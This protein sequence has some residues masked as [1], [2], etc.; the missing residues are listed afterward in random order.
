MKTDGKN[1]VY[2]ENRTRDRSL[3]KRAPNLYPSA[4]RIFWID[5]LSKAAAYFHC[6]SLFT[7][8]YHFVSRLTIWSVEKNIAKFCSS[9]EA[10]KKFWCCDFTLN[11]TGSNSNA[12]KLFKMF[13]LHCNFN[14][15]LFF[16][17]KFI[18]RNSLLGLFEISKFFSDMNLC[19]EHRVLFSN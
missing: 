16:C 11:F 2:A 1:S 18:D 3:H 4:V 14:L 9:F 6:S 7:T 19:S 5:Y 17:G 13:V 12:S 10:V 15:G 8:S